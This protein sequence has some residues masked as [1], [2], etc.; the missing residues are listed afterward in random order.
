MWSLFPVFTSHCAP[1]LANGKV[2]VTHHTPGHIPSP[3]LGAIGAAPIMGIG[4]SREISDFG[5][6]KFWG[7]QWRGDLA[8]VG[9]PTSCFKLQAFDCSLSSPPPSKSHNP[10]PC[11]MRG[12]FTCDE[13]RLCE[14][15]V[16]GIDGNCLAVLCH[17]HAG[18]YVKKEGKLAG[19]GFSWVQNHVSRRTREHV[20]PRRPLRPI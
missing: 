7:T 17:N 10:M 16:L 15:R 19:S 14:K 4:R 13:K 9:E 8:G 12:D 6:L 5:E 20:R 3:L 1:R 18:R 2:I 11:D